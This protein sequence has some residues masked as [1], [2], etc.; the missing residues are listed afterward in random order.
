M[1]D[2]P[3]KSWDRDV[4]EGVDKGS[5]DVSDSIVGA[6]KNAHEKIPVE[7]GVFFG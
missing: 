1:V 7:S 2:H 6:S 4:T 3:E 5:K